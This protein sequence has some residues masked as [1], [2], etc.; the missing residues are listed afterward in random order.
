M[1]FCLLMYMSCWD[2]YYSYPKKKGRA[3]STCLDL[4]FQ[5]TDDPLCL[6]TGCENKH[7]RVNA[8]K[9]NR[10]MASDLTFTAGNVFASAIQVQVR[11]Q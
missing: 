8:R 7:M 11:P 10:R 2:Q 9:E 5:E 3:S 1:K 6:E 4:R